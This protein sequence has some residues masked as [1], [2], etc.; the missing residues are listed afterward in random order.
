MEEKNT[1]VIKD[2]DERELFKHVMRAGQGTLISLDSEPTADEPLLEANQAGVYN[3][4]LYWRVESEI[5]VFNS[6]SQ[7]AVS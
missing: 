1:D 3:N 6:S 5:L 2:D 7:I 4:N